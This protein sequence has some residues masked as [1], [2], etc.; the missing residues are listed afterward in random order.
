M[1]QEHQEVSSSS[2]WFK[3]VWG[4][5]VVSCSQHLPSVWGGGWR[6][7]VLV[8]V[9]HLKDTVQSIVY[10]PLEDELRLCFIAELLFQLSLL[11]LIDWLSFLTFYIP[12]LL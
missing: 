4:L 6:V 12:S 5:S 3:P 8:S 10:I 2:F 11:F 9:E 1:F 7:G